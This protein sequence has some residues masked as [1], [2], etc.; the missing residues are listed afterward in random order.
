MIVR[1]P[2]RERGDLHGTVRLLREGEASSSLSSL[3][4]SS[5]SGPV[6]ATGAVQA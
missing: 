4:S 6:A 1:N 5:G 2:Q 3:S